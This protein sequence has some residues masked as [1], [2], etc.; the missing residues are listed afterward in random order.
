MQGKVSRLHLRLSCCTKLVSVCCVDEYINKNISIKVY[1]QK[2]KINNINNNDNNNNK[3]RC[4]NP[5]LF[6]QAAQ[7]VALGKRP[8][9]C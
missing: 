2:Y 8:L 6:L 9:N 5:L 7:K 4:L 1:K 3:N